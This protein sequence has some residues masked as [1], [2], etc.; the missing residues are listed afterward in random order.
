[1]ERS[2]TEDDG[3]HRTLAHADISI[4]YLTPDALPH[5]P[6]NQF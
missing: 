4:A 1:M 2:N 3:A 5:P 6:Q